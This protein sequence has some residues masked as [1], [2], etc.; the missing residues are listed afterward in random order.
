MAPPKK[1][2]SLEGVKA[3]KA[4][5]WKAFGD[6]VALNPDRAAFATKFGRKG[7]DGAASEGYDYFH[8]N[9]GKWFN[10]KNRWN[11]DRW[12]RHQNFFKAAWDLW[13][14]PADVTDPDIGGGGSGG[15]DEGGGDGGGVDDGI[16]E[17]FTPNYNIGEFDGVEMEYDD[18]YQQFVEFNATTAGGS[19]DDDGNIGDDDGSTPIGDGGGTDPID[20]I[21]PAEEAIRQFTSTH[22]RQ[23]PNINPYR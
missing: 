3:D 6:E 21:I 2:K 4:F 22:M 19:D 14:P 23:D 17:T 11:P 18:A 13:K 10:D 15:D 5:D 16:P 1:L 9:W 7:A 8:G 20:D 12:R